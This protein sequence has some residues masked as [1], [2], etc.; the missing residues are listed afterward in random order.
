MYHVDVHINRKFWFNFFFKSYA[1]FDRRD[2]ADMED[3]TQNSLSAQLHWNLSSWNFVVKKDIM[4]R[5]A[6]LQE[7]L[8]YSFEG[9]I[10]IHFEL[11]PKLFCAR[12]LMKLIFLSD[13]LSLGFAIRCIQHS[14][15]MLECVGYVSLLT[16]SFIKQY[17][18]YQICDLVGQEFNG[19]QS[20]NM[21]L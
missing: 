7:M 8:I 9:A 3:S 1:L 4:C 14:Q 5:Y 10:Y 11:W 16:L 2:L 20:N 15:A 12:T 17:F 18:F 21:L 19:R 13:C 6:F